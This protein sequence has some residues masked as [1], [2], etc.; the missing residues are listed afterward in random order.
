MPYVDYITKHFSLSLF[1]DY[2]PQNVLLYF[3]TPQQWDSV[4]KTDKVGHLKGR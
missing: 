2:A 3:D 4:Y 1:Q